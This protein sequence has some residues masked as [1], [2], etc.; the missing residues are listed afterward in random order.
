MKVRGLHIC[1]YE[2]RHIEHMIALVFLF[3]GERAPLVLFVARQT[4]REREPESREHKSQPQ[5]H[6]Q[7]TTVYEIRV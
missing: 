4:H 1:K 7:T 5:S 6:R 3:T 2:E